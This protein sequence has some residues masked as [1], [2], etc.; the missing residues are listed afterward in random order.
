[1]LHF[2]LKQP[3]HF[4]VCDHI[5]GINRK[6]CIAYLKRYESFAGKANKEIFE[7][8]QNRIWFHSAI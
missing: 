6:E 8:F 3:R 2:A 7:I 4:H 1:L 5:Q